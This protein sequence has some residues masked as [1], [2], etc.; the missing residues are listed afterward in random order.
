[1]AGYTKTRSDFEFLETIYELTDQIELD[2]EREHLMR[3][4]N[5]KTAR[6][7]YEAAISLWFNEHRYDD[8]PTRYQRRV[9]AIKDRYGV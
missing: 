1:M 4:P 3:N 9:A 2:S 7:M 6:D 8:L 5:K